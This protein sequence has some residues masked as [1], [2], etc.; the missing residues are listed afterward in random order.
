MRPSSPSALRGKVVVI[1]GASSGLGRAA[2]R[3][4]V[5]R[6]A[7]VVLAARREDALEDTAARCR[8]LGGEAHVVATDVTDEGAV[9][10]L[11]DRALELTGSIDAW[12]NNAGVTSFG[13]LAST[14]LE[15]LRRVVETNLWGSVL[16]ARAVMPV[17]ERQQHGVL[18]NVGS[19]LSKVGQPFVPGYVMSKFALRGLTEALRAETGTR[20]NIH[21]CT[22]LPY[23]ID[24][25]HFQA[26]ANLVGRKAFA[27]PPVQSPEKVASALVDLIER[28]RRE[29]HVP[30]V[31]ALGLALHALMPKPVEHV[32]HEVLT[33]WHFGPV[34]S[35][36]ARGNLWLP[37][38]EVPA[39]HGHRAPQLSL[40]ELLGWTLGHYAWLGLKR[41]ARG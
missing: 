17:F 30:R 15:D 37:P 23:A 14:P 2:A 41:F 25:P 11:K 35:R 7:R 9:L 19:I 22:L 28:P 27:M 13:S 31:A 10:R 36:D 39:E 20:R 8:E 40:A 38:A 26:G 1:T 18:V 21:V 4:L 12:V 33:R 34:Q 6:G 3:A 5:E 32:I 29:L 24:T 16:G